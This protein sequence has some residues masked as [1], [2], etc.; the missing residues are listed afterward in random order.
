VVRRQGCCM[1]YEGCGPS[2]SNTRFTSELDSLFPHG[3]DWCARAGPMMSGA[4]TATTGS[5][6]PAPSAR[7]STSQRHCRPAGSSKR[8]RTPGTGT[9]LHRRAPTSTSPASGVADAP[10]WRRWSGGSSEHGHNHAQR[11]P[12]SNSSSSISPSAGD[13]VNDF[14]AVGN[15]SGVRIERGA[16]VSRRSLPS[17]VR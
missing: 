3:P 17:G 13:S 5:W 14:V 7:F 16:G 9:S 8:Q 4:P 2:R 6:S 15:G 11:R 12:A 1:A 10:G